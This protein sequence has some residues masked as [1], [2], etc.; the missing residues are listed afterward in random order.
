MATACFDDLIHA[1]NRLKICALLAPVASLEF[2]TLCEQLGVSDS[3]LSKHIKSLDD[4]GYVV[5][6]K[7]PSAGR[8]RTWLA[9][10]PKG[11]KAFNSH[12]AALK[13]IVG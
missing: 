12:V 4:A 13:E 6:N 8:Q 7:K 5:I 3:V 11:R 10:S 2:T 1:P 9:L